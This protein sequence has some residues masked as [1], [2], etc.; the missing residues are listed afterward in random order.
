ME[1]VDAGGARIPKLGL[2]TWQNTG[3]QCTRAVRSALES[4]YR[5]VDTAAAYDNE[6]AVGRGIDAADVDRE[7]VFLTTKVW[8]SELEYDD[9]LA[10]VRSSLDALDVEYLDMVLLH[11]PHPRMPV[12]ESLDALAELVADGVVD[13]VG[14]SNYTTSQLRKARRVAD[15]PIVTNQVLYHPYKDQSTLQEYCLRNGVAL[16]AYSPLARGSAVSDERLE[17]IGDRYDRSAAQVAIRWLLQQE[18]VVAIPKSTSPDHIESNLGALEF[19]LT[20]EEMARIDRRTGPL[21]VR[22]KNRLPSL[23]RRLPI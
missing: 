4:G 14:V 15:V 13:H 8:R 20:D 19:T 7:E 17:R 11:W 6:E 18:N 16:T 12:E 21:G 10:S 2:G 23:M 5:H 1:Y 9:V 3:S 22:L